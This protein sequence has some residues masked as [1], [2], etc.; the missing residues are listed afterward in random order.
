MPS[1]RLFVPV[2]LL[3][4]RSHRLAYP[5][6]EILI[7]RFYNRSR[8]EGGPKERRGATACVPLPQQLRS[9]RRTLIRRDEIINLRHLDHP[10]E[11][12]SGPASA[13]A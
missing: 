12:S 2:P 5:T 1:R 9:E 3:D 10:Q 11:S 13:T 8:F 4:P 7:R 6:G